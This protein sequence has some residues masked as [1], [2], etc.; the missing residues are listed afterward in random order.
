M[1]YLDISKCLLE[2]GVKLL[3]IERGGPLVIGL[4]CPSQYRGPAGRQTCRH[5]LQGQIQNA[6]ISEEVGTECKLMT[7]L[8][9]V[10]PA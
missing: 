4:Y 8:Y 1:C 5:K 7:R 10:E 3:I 6:A 2:L 9:Q